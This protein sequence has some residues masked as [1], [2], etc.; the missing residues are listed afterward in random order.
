MSLVNVTI[1]RHCIRSS[2]STSFRKRELA[3]SHISLFEDSLFTCIVRCCFS[4]L[5]SPLLFAPAA[6][7]PQLK[8]SQFIIPLQSLAFEIGHFLSPDPASGIRW[9][10]SL[11][12]LIKDCQQH[13][14]TSLMVIDEDKGLETYGL[15]AIILYRLNDIIVAVV[16]VRGAEFL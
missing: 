5:R 15:C 14:D 4:R 16:E 12:F 6:P 8:F 7:N 2:S 11:E 9:R 3:C 10:P 1:Q 13:V